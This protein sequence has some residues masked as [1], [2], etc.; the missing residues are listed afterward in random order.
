MY[1]RGSGALRGAAWLTVCVALALAGSA[2]KR[3]RRAHAVWVRAAEGTTCFGVQGGAVR[4]ASER[5]HPV[6]FGH[7]GSEHERIPEL[8]GHTALVLGRDG[9]CSR[10]P[11][12]A[13]PSCVGLATDLLALAPGQVLCRGASYACSLEH[14]VVRCS[15]DP[16]TPLGPAIEGPP[17]AV[18]ALAGVVEIA[19]GVAHACARLANGTMGCWGDV[20]SQGLGATGLRIQPGLFGVTGIASAGHA[21]YAV[22]R[23]GAVFGWGADVVPSTP[24]RRGQRLA[25]PTPIFLRP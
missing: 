21:A 14:G 2:C 5:P 7:A 23:D 16:G 24:G 10:A 6:L 17:H 1:S 25:V 19:C 12:Q 8:E 20:A 13:E 18:L 22:T 11:G 3:P 15:G 9:A 4:C